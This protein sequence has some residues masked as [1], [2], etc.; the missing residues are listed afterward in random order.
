MRKVFNRFANIYPVSNTNKIYKMYNTAVLS[1]KREIFS[2]VL[3]L[4]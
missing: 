1:L 3:T 4:F 2:R